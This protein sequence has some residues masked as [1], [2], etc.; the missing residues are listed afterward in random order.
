MSK[1]Y[2]LILAALV[3]CLTMAR[4]QYDPNFSH[5]WAMETSYNAAAAGKESKLN[6]TAAYNMTLT[7]FENN[8]RTMYASA[9]MPV[10]FLNHFHGIGASFINDEIGLFSHKTIALQY[11]FKFALFG[12]TMSVG[13][14]PGFISETFDGSKVDTETPNDPAFPKSEATGSSFDL[15]AGLYFT[16]KLFYAGLS[17]K[18]L[19]SPTVALGETQ[20]FSISPTYYFTAGCNIKLRNPFFSIHPTAFV[21]YDGTAYRADVTARLKYSYEKKMF[22]GGVGYSPTNSVTLFLGGTFHGIS[23]GYSYEVYTSAVSF[24]NGGHELCVGY[25]MDIDFQ[26]KGRNRHK[27]VRLL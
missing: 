5:Y 26:K 23:L 25:Q 8:P 4:A 9:D 17:A 1:R 6:I 20:D 7:G 21:R 3:G 14:Q 15:G 18:H 16:H 2:Y 12:G 22:Y 19:M 24:G 11:S 10:R 13:V 27:S